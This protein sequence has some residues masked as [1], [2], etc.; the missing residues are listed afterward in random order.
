MQNNFNPVRSLRIIYKFLQI[1]PSMTEKNNYILVSLEDEKSKSVAEVLSSPTCKKI[2][3][4]LAETKEASQKDLSEK[5]K[6]PMNTVEYNIKK[7]L[8]SGFVQKRKNFFW[9]K[10]GKKI[11]MYELSNKSILISHKKSSTEKFKS[12]LPA[13]ILSGALSFLLWT[14]QKVGINQESVPS[15]VQD[16]FYAAA[17]IA[18]K[19]ST[20]LANYGNPMWAWFL[21]GSLIAIFIFSIVNWRKL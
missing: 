14:L 21:L 1:N 9:S 16:T 19:E 5:L 3:N 4:Y 13:V 2:I 8:S 7:L 15:S 11:V 17:E 6:I 10:K 20:S 12:I 18:T